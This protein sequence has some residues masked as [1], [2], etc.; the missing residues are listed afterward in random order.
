MLADDAFAVG[1]AARAACAGQRFERRRMLKRN[2]RVNSIFHLVGR[3]L[4]MLAL[5]LLSP[6]L[7]VS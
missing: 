5:I 4:Q 3:I 1:R 7:F 6:L 2:H